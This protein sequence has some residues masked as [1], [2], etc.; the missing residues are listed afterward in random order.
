MEKSQ[1]HEPVIEVPAEKREA[2][3]PPVYATTFVQQF[4]PG[5]R[6]DE[7]F[8]RDVLEVMLENGTAS[9]KKPRDT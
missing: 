6:V 5:D 1:A 2:K 3:N 9:Y 4:Q 7:H 8:T